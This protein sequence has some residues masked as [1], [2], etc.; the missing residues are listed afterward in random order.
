M[1]KVTFEEFVNVRNPVYRAIPV[2]GFLLVLLTFIP[3]IHIFQN[4]VDS[5]YK[6]IL[7]VL[8]GITII[9]FIYMIIFPQK[10][11]FY[12][13]CSFLYS[14]YWSFL[15]DCFVYSFL[16]TVLFLSILVARG[17]F[18]CRMK[19][20]IFTVSF[21]YFLI[22]FVQLR[23]GI[24]EFLKYISLWAFTWAILF[25]SIYYVLTVFYEY[26]RRIGNIPLSLDDFPDL[27]EADILIV[28]RILQNEKYDSI[29]REFKIS[30]RTVKR[31]CSKIFEHYS[32]ADKLDF[33]AKYSNHSV[34][35]KGVEYLTKDRNET[36]ALVELSLRCH[37]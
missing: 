26:V 28:C 6:E 9:S 13:L 35:Y 27:D 20:R 24:M 36:N 18:K 5:P 37:Q 16:N 4:P 34:S 8:K 1:K 29:A 7:F 33:L 2:V 12:G 32:C 15:P 23:F 3:E 21:F 11:G 30:E 22:S 31:R 14:L 17:Y 19:R 25:V 10:I